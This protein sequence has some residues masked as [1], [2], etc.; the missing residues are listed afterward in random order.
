MSAKYRF[1]ERHKNVTLVFEGGRKRH[2]TTNVSS[3]TAVSILFAIL[4]KASLFLS[5]NDSLYATSVNRI[6]PL[7]TFFLGVGAS[8]G[9]TIGAET[10]ENLSI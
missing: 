4:M 10:N 1:S 2:V 6:E 3:L 7:K 5:L 9:Y 8:V